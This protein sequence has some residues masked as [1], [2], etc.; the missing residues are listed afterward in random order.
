MTEQRVACRREILR[1]GL[2]LARIKTS[3]P[4]AAVQQV[5]QVSTLHDIVHTR[6]SA[7]DQRLQWRTCYVV[8]NAGPRF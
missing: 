8:S 1:A 4:A 7:T 3:P 5:D 2:R 6:P